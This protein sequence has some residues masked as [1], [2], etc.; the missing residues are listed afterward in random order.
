MCAERGFL[1]PRTEQAAGCSWPL[2]HSPPCSQ[3]PWAQA[4]ASSTAPS[5]RLLCSGPPVSRGGHGLWDGR[6]SVSC[7]PAAVRWFTSLLRLREGVVAM[8]QDGVLHRIEDTG[9]G[10]P[11]DTERAWGAHTDIRCWSGSAQ[12]SERILNP[13]RD[14]TPP[15]LCVSSHTELLSEHFFHLCIT[16]T[17]RL[18]TFVHSEA[19]GHTLHLHPPPT[20]WNPTPAQ[21]MPLSICLHVASAGAHQHED[22]G[23]QNSP[24]SVLGSLAVSTARPRWFLRFRGPTLM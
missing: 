18:F 24:I 21:E 10:P 22:G 12:A 8:E 14:R 15:P 11:T 17:L 13:S 16:T 9:K 23:T 2:L 3:T 19:P 4:A 1:L 6:G 7:F 5:P 20:A